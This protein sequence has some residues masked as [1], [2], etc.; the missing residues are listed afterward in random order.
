MLGKGIL[1]ACYWFIPAI[2]C[3]II[4]IFKFDPLAK[5]GICILI[6]AAICYGSNFVFGAPESFQVDF[7]NW[8]QC[9]NGNVNLL[10]FGGMMLIGVV[11]IGVGYVRNKKIEGPYV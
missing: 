4:C 7:S 6:A 2:I 3:T 1:E 5:I 10:A 9:V 8:E 11:F